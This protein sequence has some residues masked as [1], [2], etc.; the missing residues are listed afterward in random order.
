MPISVLINERVE[1]IPTQ[2]LYISGNIQDLDR[3]DFNTIE[4]QSTIYKTAGR[5]FLKSVPKFGVSFNSASLTAFLSQFNQTTYSGNANAI[6]RFNGKANSEA[7]IYVYNFNTNELSFE[8]SKF[9]ESGILNVGLQSNEEVPMK[10]IVSTVP[11][12]K[13][14]ILRHSSIINAL[15]FATS[16]KVTFWHVRVQSVNKTDIWARLQGRAIYRQP[17]PGVFWSP[18]S[19]GPAYVVGLAGG[20][21]WREIVP[22]VEGMTVKYQVGVSAW[23]N[24]PDPYPPAD[25]CCQYRKNTWWHAKIMA[26]KSVKDS[27]GTVGED[28]INISF[29]IT[30]QFTVDS[31][32]Y[33]GRCVSKDVACGWESGSSC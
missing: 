3:I 16:I 25:K 20:A 11:L 13:A 31:Y 32:S 1:E 23:C 4:P 10:V 2:P 29:H 22:V 18:P 12:P 5:V 21:D 15:P 7:F 28:D 33:L 24:T 19:G 9:N 30:G 27:W 14:L 6:L 26:R 8:K 17:L